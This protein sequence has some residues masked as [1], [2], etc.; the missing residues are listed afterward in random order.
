[1]TASPHKSVSLAILSTDSAETNVIVSVEAAVLW[2]YYGN[3]MLT[4]VCAGRY[5]HK[6]T[7][8]PDREYG[9][10]SRVSAGK[11]C[12]VSLQPRKQTAWKT[13]SSVLRDIYTPAPST[14]TLV[15][16]YAV[17]ELQQ[18]DGTLMDICIPEEGY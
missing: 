13:C 1:M 6:I 5:C 16:H 4:N 9:D 2:Q 14:P 18:S 12:I 15:S 17:N 3:I 10:L 11:H 7:A 8:D